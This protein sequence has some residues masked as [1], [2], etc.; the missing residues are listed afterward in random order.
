MY[1]WFGSNKFVGTGNK[2]FMLYTSRQHVSGFLVKFIK[3]KTR[4][5][6]FC[7]MSNN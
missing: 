7:N 4:K 1:K 6:L 5:L 2:L 3:E